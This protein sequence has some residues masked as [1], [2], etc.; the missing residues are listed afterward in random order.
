M[1]RV[2]PAWISGYSGMI[3]LSALLLNIATF[4]VYNGYGLILTPMGDALGLSHFQ[5]GS[6][7]TGFSIAGTIAGAV[8]GFLATRYG[9][10]LVIWSVR[11]QRRHRSDPPGYVT[12]LY[13]RAGDERRGRS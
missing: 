9:T 11:Y 3:L 1:V 12:K 13:L 8:A 2:A 7:T 4:L 5:E 10:R 6:L